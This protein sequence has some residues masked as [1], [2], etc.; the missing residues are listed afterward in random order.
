MITLHE[1]CLRIL[2]QRSFRVACVSVAERHFK[3]NSLV[4]S[5]SAALHELQKTNVVIST[6]SVEVRSR[7]QS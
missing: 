5:E 6:R 3:V 7:I 2:L 4:L 1:Q